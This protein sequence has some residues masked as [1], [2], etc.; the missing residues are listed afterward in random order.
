MIP[1]LQEGAL[2]MSSVLL[3]LRHVVQVAYTLVILLVDDVRF[4][5][6]SLRSSAALAAENLFLRKQVGLYQEGHVWRQALAVVQPATWTRWHRQEFR[7]FWR[8]K[9]RP[10]RPSLPADLQALIRRMAYENPT[11]GQERIANE[12]LLKLGLRVS[13]QT[14]RKSMPEP[15]NHSHGTRAISQRWQTFAHNPA[16]ALIACDFCVVTATFRPLYVFVL[17]EHATHRILHTNVTPHPAVPWTLQ[18]L[19][20]AIPSDHGY[21]SIPSMTRW[22]MGGGRACSGRP[23]SG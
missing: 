5:R 23:G 17:M 3:F 14:V 13:P 12:S 8:W 10:G 16:T 15:R 19:R 9:S 7:L 21:R 1:L 6:L 18:Q 20:E 2:H 22:W 11:W 4:L